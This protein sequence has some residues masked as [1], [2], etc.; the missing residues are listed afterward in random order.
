L[1]LFLLLHHTTFDPN[2]RMSAD[3]LCS[4]FEHNV[5]RRD[6]FAPMFEPRRLP[7][8]AGGGVRPV[9]IGALVVAP[10]QSQNFVSI[11]DSVLGMFNFLFAIRLSH[12]DSFDK[13]W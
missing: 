8:Q 13:S 3:L 7:R 1:L 6:L 9:R 10:Q 5:S 11:F 12:F 2:E 4:L